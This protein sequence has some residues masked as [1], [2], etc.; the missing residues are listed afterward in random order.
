M[1]LPFVWLS[2]ISQGHSYLRKINKYRQE[3]VRLFSSA[4]INVQVSHS[5]GTFYSRLPGDYGRINL[6]FLIDD[7]HLP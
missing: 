4:L 5:S 7:H 2:N 3:K 1:N 6:I